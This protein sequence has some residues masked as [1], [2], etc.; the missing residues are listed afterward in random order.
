MHITLA[1][2]ILAFLAFSL[3]S[4]LD[5]SACSEINARGLRLYLICIA[6]WAKE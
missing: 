5:R 6:R 1:I 4:V 2:A 3:L